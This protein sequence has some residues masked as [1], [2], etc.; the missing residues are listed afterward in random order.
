MNAEGSLSA[1]LAG[2][3]AGASFGPVNV[4][5]T[6]VGLVGTLAEARRFAIGALLGD[7][8]LLGSSLLLIE[9]ATGLLDPRVDYWWLHLLAATFIAAVAT[10]SLVTGPASATA[11][12]GSAQAGHWLLRGLGFSL[13]SPFGLV[14]WSG[15]AVATASKGGFGVVLVLLGDCFWFLTWLAILAGGRL[16]VGAG[17]RQSIHN[18]ANVLLLGCALLLVLK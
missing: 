15:I 2:F 5:V 6:R 8:C 7:A 4:E 14:L 18:A 1:L 11:P 9:L 3:G 17:A 12:S 16:R 13:L 10:R